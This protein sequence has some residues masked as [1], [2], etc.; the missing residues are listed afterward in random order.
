MNEWMLVGIEFR[1]D[2]DFFSG[3]GLKVRGDRVIL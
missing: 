3:S 1:C 2:F